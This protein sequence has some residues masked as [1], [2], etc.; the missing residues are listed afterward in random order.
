[1]ADFLDKDAKSEQPTERRRR[2]VR[3][4]GNVARSSDLCAAASVLTVAALLDSLAGGMAQSLGGTLRSAL[5]AQAWVELDTPRLMAELFALAGAV[6]G[7]LLPALA[8][9]LASAVAINAVQVGFVFTTEPLIPRL[10]RIDPLAGLRRLWSLDGS[11][12]FL[13]GVLKLAV[14]VAIVAGFLLGRIPELLHGVDADVASFWSQLGGWLSALALQMALG[15]AV[16]AALD[17]GYQLW[18]F[19]QEIKMTPQE[20][21]DELRQTEGDPELRRK[22]RETH[23][24]RTTSGPMPR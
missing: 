20:V 8:L 16:L 15:L 11:V 3:E 2:E 23:R 1:M 7:A 17:Y 5:S 10:E 4:R 24:M 22:R 14:A 12:R 18:K 13:A 19:E 21:R 6:A 9:V